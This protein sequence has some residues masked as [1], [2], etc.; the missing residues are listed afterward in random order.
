M[1]LPSQIAICQGLSVAGGMLQIRKLCSKGHLA[2][3]WLLMAA[4]KVL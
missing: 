2:G 1:L 4:I 3:L